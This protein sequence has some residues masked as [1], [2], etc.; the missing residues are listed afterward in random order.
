MQRP[1]VQVAILLA[2][3]NGAKFIHKFMES[4][5][6]QNFLDF[7]VYI[8]DDGS[9]DSTI[10]ITAQYADQL[11][12]RF[13][14]TDKRLG[15]AVGFFHIMAQAEEN[16]DFYL[17]AD[18]DDWWYADK[19]ERAVAALSGRQE[20]IVLYCSRLEYVNEDLQHIGYS[21][22]PKLLT[23]ENAA[24]ENVATGCTVAFTKR[25]RR[26]VL[27]PVPYGFIM[28]DWWLY[29]F[30][31]AM[32]HVIYDSKSSIKYR[33][34][35]NNAIG[36]AT[37][38]VEDFR[39]RWNRFNARDGGVHLLSHQLKAFLICYGDRLE[40]QHHKLLEQVLTAKNS[41]LGRFQLALHSPVT[42]Q[43]LIDTLI[44]RVLFLL[45]RY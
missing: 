8:R 4:L 6:S 18:Q 39:R 11:D 28:H 30:C 22:I 16:H 1:N 3:Y 12:L 17:F 15:P 24:V 7:C 14:K 25:T 2:T 9:T 36:A 44:L 40:P 43:S 38:A 5:C 37:S 26:E 41:R 31:A 20:E 19:V 35:S 45:G 33:Q 34:H 29:L 23:I 10:K 13:L 42:R 21:R 32:G 27:K